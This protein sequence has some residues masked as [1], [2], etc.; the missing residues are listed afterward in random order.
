MLK[1]ELKL[2]IFVLTKSRKVCSKFKYSTSISSFPIISFNRFKAS[3]C[4][5]RLSISP[6]SNACVPV[7]IFPSEIS[8][9]NSVQKNTI[10]SLI[11]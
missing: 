10:N 11:K 6:L 8:F 2:K 3:D 5:P 9:T 4:V 7:H 1:K